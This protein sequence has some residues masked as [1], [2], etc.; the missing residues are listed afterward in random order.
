MKIAT[1]WKGN[2]QLVAM[3]LLMV[4]HRIGGVEPFL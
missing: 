1:N 4:Q 3:F 2:L